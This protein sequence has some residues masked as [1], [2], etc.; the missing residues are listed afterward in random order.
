MSLREYGLVVIFFLALYFVSHGSPAQQGPPNGRSWDVIRGGGP[1]QQELEEFLESQRKI[2]DQFYKNETQLQ[3]FQA[4][5][6][7]ILQ[8]FYQNQTQLQQFQASQA[9]ILQQFS[10]N[11]R[12]LIRQYSRRQ[13]R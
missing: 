13:E 7:K 12:Q 10:E 9:K 1:Q 11:Q 5:Q 6:A 2:L 8:Q 4:S 3:Q